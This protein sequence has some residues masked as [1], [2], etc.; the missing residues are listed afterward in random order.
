VIAVNCVCV[1][2]K[3]CYKKIAKWN[4]KKALGNISDLF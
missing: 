2:K 1:C 3:E 4:R